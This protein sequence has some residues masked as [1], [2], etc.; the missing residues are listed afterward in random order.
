M[1]IANAVD[2]AVHG[3]GFSFTNSDEIKKM[4]VKRI[5][6]PTTF[7]PITRQPTHGGLYDPALGP[8]EKSQR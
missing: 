5:C 6:N 2:Y 7:D 8:S 4:S 1:N 3:V